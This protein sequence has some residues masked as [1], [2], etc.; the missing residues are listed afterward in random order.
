MI[1]PL[2]ILSFVSSPLA[3]AAAFSA[4]GYLRAG[5]GTNGKGAKQECFVNRGSPTNEFRLGNE[6][7]IYGESAFRMEFPGTTGQDPKF[8]SQVRFAYSPPANSS[9]EDNDSDGRDINIVEAFAEAYEIEGTNLS[10]WAGKRFYRDVDMHIF[11][12][13]YYGQMNGNGAGVGGIPLGRGK[14]AAAWLLETGSTRTNLGKNAVQIVDLRFTEWKIAEDQELNFWAAY[15]MAPGSSSVTNSQQYAHRKGWLLG[16]RW[17]KSLDGG[18]LDLALIHGRNLLEGLNI[19]GGA[20]VG[21]D[22]NR[23]DAYRWRIAQDL[24]LK[25][26]DKF[27]LH[28]SSGFEHWDPKKPNIDS[29]GTWWA[30]GTRPIY[31]VSKNLQLATEVGHSQIHNREDRNSTSQGVGPRKLTRLTIAPQ[32]ALGPGLWSRPVLRAF[33]SYSF[34]NNRNRD[35]VGIDAPSYAGAGAGQAIGVQTEIW[36]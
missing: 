12:W 31:F 6:C 27:A 2:I 9:F 7:S 19:Y 8:A 36:F 3:N 14:L 29:R 25:I 15:G 28:F 13:Y 32:Y 30:V 16:S 21:I 34:W 17:R 11:D 23:S 5:T 4:H 33:Y 35:F 26:S 24:A 10:L 22:D 1:L 18:F 20:L